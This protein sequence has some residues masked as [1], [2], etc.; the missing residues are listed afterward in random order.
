LLNQT[1]SVNLLLLFWRIPAAVG[2][3]SPESA[4]LP[5]KPR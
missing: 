2:R 1:L 4:L 5:I 3:S